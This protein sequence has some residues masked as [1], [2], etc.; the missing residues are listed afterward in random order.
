METASAVVADLID[1]A[2]GRAPLTFPRLDLW[3][4]RPPREVQ[5]AE[6][7]SRR[8][9]L[10]FS[11][12]DMPHVFADIADILGRHR[13]SLASIIQHEAPEIEESVPEAR[14]VVPVVV[15]THRTLEGRMRAAEAELEQLASLRAPIVRMPVAD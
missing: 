7:L 11:V 9:Y 3:Q 15:M 8:Y 14:P 4:E 12:D 13:I 5:P 10:R 2:I 6:E 1:M